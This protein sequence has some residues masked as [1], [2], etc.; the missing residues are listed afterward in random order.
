MAKHNGVKGVKGVHQQRK[1]KKEGKKTPI[2]ASAAPTAK[3]AGKAAAKADPNNN[4]ARRA[5]KTQWK[6]FSKKGL[7][8]LS[9]GELKA[10]QKMSLA[11][12]KDVRES[13]AKDPKNWDKSQIHKSREFTREQSQNDMTSFKTKA[14]VIKALGKAD[15]K[16]WCDSMLA[17]STVD[18]NG[19]RWYPYQ[20]T[21]ISN[22][23][24]R[25]DAKQ[26]KMSGAPSGVPMLTNVPTVDKKKDGGREEEDDQDESSDEEGQ[27]ES[28][29]EESE[30]EKD[31]ED[32]DE[33]NDEDRDTHHTEAEKKKSDQTE[34][35]MKAVLKAVVDNVEGASSVP[36]KAKAKLMTELSNIFQQIHSKP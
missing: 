21:F 8:D 36:R 30:G 6:N 2:V 26:F 25:T 22:I 9:E 7:K 12:K 28:E 14:G 33:D 1:V 16:K 13:W 15:G 24:R 19:I 23:N 31:D 17:D 11:L 35:L 27:E 18:D 5:E 20:E 34:M 29:G 10:Y 32:D 3:P 4:A